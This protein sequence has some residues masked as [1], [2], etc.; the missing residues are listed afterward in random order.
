VTALRRCGIGALVVGSLLV[1]AVFASPQDEVLMAS[2]GT[3]LKGRMRS[4]RHNAELGLDRLD[5]YVIQPGATFSF[6][7][8]VG[9]CSRDQ[10][11]RKAPVSYNG[12]LV[13][14]WGGGVC[15]TSTTLY[16]AALLAGMQIVERNRHR[17]APSYVPAGRDA[18][19]AY[20]TIDL[21]F[22]NPYPFAVWIKGEVV[23]ERLVLGIHGEHV[24]SARPE[25]VQDV[26]QVSAPRLFEIGARP[27]RARLRNSGKTGYEVA[28]YRVTGNRRELLSVDSYPAM[29]K[30]VEY[31]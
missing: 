9:T 19:V 12:Q 20:D 15:Q 18:A 22:R 10:G 27:G 26:R 2:Y 11:Y 21:Q 28:T 5:G 6:N 7:K 3:S 17:F 13:E 30:V 24:L 1:A 23:G 16:N 31:R 25:V 29:H 4:Q 14:N 8:V